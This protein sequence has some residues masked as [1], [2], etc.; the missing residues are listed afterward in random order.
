MSRLIRSAALL[1]LLACLHN[2]A[3]AAE[4]SWLGDDYLIVEA[5]DLDDHVVMDITWVMPTISRTSTG[6]L[7]R[8]ST[9]QYIS[10]SGSQMIPKLVVSHWIIHDRG[11]NT[12]SVELI[13]RDTFSYSAIDEV[14][15]RVYHGN[16]LVENRTSIPSYIR[17][18]FGDDEIYGG[19]SD[20]RLFG[21]GEVEYESF[22]FPILPYNEVADGRDVIF[23][24]RGNDV[25]KS[26]N[27][28]DDWLEGGD[29]DDELYGAPMWFGAWFPGFGVHLWGQDGEDT[30]FFNSWDTLFD[31]SI[32]G[33]G[34]SIGSDYPSED[35]YMIVI[36]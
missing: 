8:T 34:L 6:G 26:G 27:S 35:G 23:G 12:E 32:W 4:I 30:Y 17:G 31:D 1:A 3:A 16:D 2:P 14:E 18:G 19:S 28:K 15:V 22:M 7:T 24:G 33:Q 36:D 29:G 5:S 9:N 21:G 25:L 20:D 13:S 11:R 10:T